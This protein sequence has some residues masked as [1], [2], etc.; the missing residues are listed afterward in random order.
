MSHK[1]INGTEMSTVGTISGGIFGT[2]TVGLIVQ[3]IILAILGA[4]IGAV[5]GFFVTRWLKKTF[6]ET[7][8]T[9][10]KSDETI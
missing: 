5:V 1:H 10:A 8:V 6:G 2:I 9:K 7:E 3:T 4:C